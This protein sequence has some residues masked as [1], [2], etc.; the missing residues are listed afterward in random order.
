MPTRYP[1]FNPDMMDVPGNDSKH[2]FT[3]PN[4]GGGPR[5]QPKSISANQRGGFGH[6]GNTR[7]S[8]AA[9]MSGGRSGS[10]NPASRGGFRGEAR[11]GAFQPE[12]RIPKHGG[13]PQHRGGSGSGA[14]FGQPGQANVPGGKP[15]HGPARGGNASGS[16][17]KQISGH[18]QR[19]AM[20]AR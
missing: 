6:N 2:N 8:G 10:G 11:G 12:A 5:A 19:K 16:T 3:D 14:N 4:A 20:G 15:T 18:F 17:F 7:V 1:V 13:S 9:S